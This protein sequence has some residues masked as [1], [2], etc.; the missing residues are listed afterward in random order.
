MRKLLYVTF[1]NS[2]EYSGGT[3]CAK[4]NLQSLKDLLGEDQV[5]AYFLKPDKGERNVK[6]HLQRTLGIL[7]GY[8]GGLTD[9]HCKNILNLIAEESI[10][11]FFIDSSQLG[12]LAKYAKHQ[13]PSIRIH[14]FFHNIEY[15]FFRSNVIDCKNYSHFFW[16]P[17]AKQNERCAC[18]YSDTIIALNNN[19]STRLKQLYGRQADVVIPISMKD[20]YGN[21]TN[22]QQITNSHKQALFVGS[23]FFGNTKG[24]TWLCNDILPHTDIHLTIVGAGMED[25]PDLAPY[26]EAA[27]FMILPI[28]TGGGMKVKTTEALKYGKYIIGTREALEGYDVNATIAKQCGN[29][30]D[31]IQAISHFHIPYKYNPASRKLFIEKYSYEASLKSFKDIFKA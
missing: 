6:G 18:H 12:L 23:Y 25:V 8:L 26:Y 4:R 19:D 16:I 5:I 9:K 22:M 15:D 14:T 10:T 28:I 24:L 17:M 1:D 30:Q 11:D 13:K 27:D 7:K 3:Q 20:D 29:A 2:Q 21:H 31:F